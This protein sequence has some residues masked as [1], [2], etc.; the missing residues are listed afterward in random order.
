MVGLRA[1]ASHLFLFLAIVILVQLSAVSVAL[2]AVSIFRD[3]ARAAMIAFAVFG[4]STFA[5]GCF[6]PANLIPV[7]VNWVKWISYVVRLSTFDY[8]LGNADLY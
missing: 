7:Y 3:F 8:I 1:G 6:I 5:G 4:S 2:F